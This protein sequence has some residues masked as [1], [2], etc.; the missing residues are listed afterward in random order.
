M[1]MSTKPLRRNLLA[2]TV[3]TLES[4]RFAL[5][6]YSN[7]NVFVTFLTIESKAEI[8]VWQ[9][10]RFYMGSWLRMPHDKASGNRS[11]RHLNMNCYATK[12]PIN[13]VMGI[14]LSIF[15]LWFSVGMQILF[16]VIRYRREIIL[17]R[18]CLLPYYNKQL[19]LI[20]YHIIYNLLIH[21]PVTS[22]RPISSVTQMV[23]GKQPS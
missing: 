20:I 9:F 4:H 14:M 18:V 16:A 11:K 8:S 15:H 5:G 1:W 19:F 10:S 12:G 22:V 13:A 17:V 2:L 6:S 21:K 3:K 7:S 23:K